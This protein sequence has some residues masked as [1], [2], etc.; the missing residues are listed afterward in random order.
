[1]KKNKLNKSI[2]G[3]LVLVLILSLGGC[4]EKKTEEV[5]E[6]ESVVQVIEE[7]YDAE[8]NKIDTEAN[9]GTI[10]Q[11]GKDAGREY[12]DSTLFLGDSNTVRFQGYEDEDGKRFTSINNSIGVVG[13]GVGAISSLKCVELEGKGR[14]TMVDAVKALQ[15]ERVIIFFG[16]NNLNGTSTD[17][18]SFIKTYR[19][20][21][22]AIQKAY[23]SVDMI[24]GSIFPVAQAR[25]Y[26]HVSMTQIDAYNK[27]ILAMCEEEGYKFLNA[28]EA[29]KDE[30]T[31]YAKKGYC[32]SDGLH[33]SKEG[34]TALFDYI[35]THSYITEDDRPKPLAAIPKVIGVPSGL[36]SDN[37]LAT[38]SNRIPVEFTC[39]AG[40]YLTGNTSQMVA[41]GAA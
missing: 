26:P 37:P 24:I 6:E 15:P 28:S 35:R 14:V 27:A 25:D 23:P 5:E 4:G 11:K 36:I 1:M 9:E 31:G 19:D 8:E 10:I 12:L 30:K 33:L 34:I 21:L 2:I 16:T 41:S 20:N 32:I 3:I 22:K 13:M 29:L 7:D 40:G 18:T 39:S 38:S 17:A